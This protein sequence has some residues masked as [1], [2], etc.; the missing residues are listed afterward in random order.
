[1]DEEV[2][3]EVARLNHWTEWNPGT[4]APASCHF[5]L[6]ET[7]GFPKLTPEEE[8]EASKAFLAILIEAMRKPIES[9]Q[10]GA[11]CFHGV[12]RSDT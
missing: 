8:A 2:E 5:Y 6:P 4:P 1:M 7:A 9:D 11:G 10:L 3:D 12:L